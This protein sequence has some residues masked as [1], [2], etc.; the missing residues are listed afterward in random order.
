MHR[1]FTSFLMLALCLF[2]PVLASAQHPGRDSGEYLILSAHYGTERQYMDVVQRL[3][4]LARQDRRFQ[5]RNELFG[6]DPALNVVK[7]LRILA[8]DPMGRE[9][10]FEYREGSWVDGSQFLG[11]D[12]GDWGPEADRGRRGDEG[13]FVI[14]TAQY[15]TAPRHVDVTERLRELARADRPFRADNRSFGVDPHRGRVKTLRIFA[16]GPNGKERMFEFREG[17]LVDGSMFRGWRRGDWGHGKDRWSGR[18][19]GEERGR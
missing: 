14:L 11:W 13:E 3:R 16:R 2:F 8:R 5:V 15:G 1:R 12:R 10:V 6:A 17:S 7:S 18:W 4:E 9:R 19:D